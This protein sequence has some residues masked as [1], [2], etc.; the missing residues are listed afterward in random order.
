MKITQTSIGKQLVFICLKFTVQICA[1][2]AA[3]LIFVRTSFLFIFF[4]YYFIT[5]LLKLLLKYTSSPSLQNT[6]PYNSNNDQTITKKKYIYQIRWSIGWWLV[7]PLFA[8]F[9]LFFCLLLFSNVQCNVPLQN[10]AVE[11]TTKT[12]LT[13]GHIMTNIFDI[14]NSI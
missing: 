8:A 14:G 10:N 6:T 7:K 4:N 11:T 12:T 2:C 3:L 13:S 1:V 9:A 5:L